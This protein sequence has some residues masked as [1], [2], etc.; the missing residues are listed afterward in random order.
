[1][2]NHLVK[3]PSPLSS[4]HKGAGRAR[5]DEKQ[6]AIVLLSGGLDSAT[7]LY[8]AVSKGYDCRCLIFDYGQRHK[9]EIES[10]K[11]IAKS[12][13]AAYEIIKFD[14]PW[15]GSALLDTRI[16][17]PEHNNPI[18]LKLNNRIPVTYVPA[19][20]TIFLSFAVS[21]AEAIGASA[22]FI[23]ANAVDFSGYP[24][25]R[26]EYYR[27]FDKLVRH[28]TKAGA[29][30]KKIRI[31]T[32]LIYKT[33]SE[34]IKLGTK[35]GVPYEYTWSCYAGGNRPCLKCDSCVFRGKGFKEAGI[36]DPLLK[37][38]KIVKA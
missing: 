9:K 23:G 12:C 33:K 11:E 19:R 15:K 29:E 2:R 6:K 5:G 37:R 36:K 38:L 17:V 24:D 1:M 4:P 3:Y 14:L 27:V 30:K 34:I 13:G 22:V 7:A 8:Y 35:L 21:C 26:P 28:G 16:K 25:C 31:F 32:P 18:T 20:N 10:A